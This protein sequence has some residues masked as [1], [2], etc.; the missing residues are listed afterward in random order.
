M[1]ADG[2][3]RTN[4]GG[5]GDQ[6]QLTWSPDGQQLAFLMPRFPLDSDPEQNIEIW[7]MNADGTGRVNITNTLWNELTPDWSRE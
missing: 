7:V 5:S 2:T 1:N 4:V 3:A 6:A